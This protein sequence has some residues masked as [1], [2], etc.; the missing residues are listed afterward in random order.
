MTQP[1][2]SADVFPDK[3]GPTFSRRGITFAGKPRS[4]E[5]GKRPKKGPF[6]EKRALIK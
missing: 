2:D 4:N 3:S 5:P 6:R 1:G